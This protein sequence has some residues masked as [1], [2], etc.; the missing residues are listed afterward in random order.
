MRHRWLVLAVA[1]VWL[2]AAGWVASGVQLE[3]DLF[4]ALPQ[5]KVMQRYRALLQASGN[6][7]FQLSDLQLATDGVS[8]AARTTRGACDIVSRL[9]Q[10]DRTVAAWRA[11]FQV[12]CMNLRARLAAASGNAAEAIALARRSLNAARSTPRP[13][14]RATLSFAAFVTGGNALAQAGNREEAARWWRMAASAIP[15]SIQLSPREK[16]QLA[17]VHL[18]LGNVAA[19]R[20]FRAELDAIG[21]RYPGSTITPPSSA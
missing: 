17:F 15:S 14:D 16:A 2:L 12:L 18:Q 13:V 5:D 8:E 3:E 10:R 7:R 21:Y 4:Q 1:L 11:K 9:L 6:A 20:R 19:A